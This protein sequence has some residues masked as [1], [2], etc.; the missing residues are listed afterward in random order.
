MTHQSSGLFSAFRR[1]TSLV[2]VGFL[3]DPG[4]PAAVRTSIPAN[5]RMQF[6][7]PPLAEAMDGTVGIERLVLTSRLEV[8]GPWLVFTNKSAILLCQGTPFMSIPFLSF[9]TILD[10]I[11]LGVQEFDNNRWKTLFSVALRRK[12]NRV[13][14]AIR[15]RVIGVE[16][17]DINL[18]TLLQLLVQISAVSPS[19]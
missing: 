11:G 6:F 8:A 19:A 4:I 1:A 18:Q 17:L 13:V 14:R 16:Q 5:E 7:V 3:S 10:E 2:G 15:N 12:E 9:D